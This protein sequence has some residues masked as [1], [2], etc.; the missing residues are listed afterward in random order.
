MSLTRRV[1]TLEQAARAQL[2]G[3]FRE[4]RRTQV[5]TLAPEHARAALEWHQY[6]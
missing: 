5:A 6:E 2:E 4:A 3:R 1:G